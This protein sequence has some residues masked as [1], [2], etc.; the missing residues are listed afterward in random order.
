MEGGNFGSVLNRIAEAG[1]RGQKVRPGDYFDQDGF[2][3]CGT[4]GERRQT[5]VNFPN[6]GQDGAP[7]EI[8]T[9]V[10]ISCRC[11][12]E[13]EEAE[14]KEA[15]ASKDMQRISYLRKASL[16]DELFSKATFDSY[17]KNK[18]NELNLKLCL[19][20]T[21]AFD[22][23]M[24]KNQGLL[25]WGGVGTGKSYSAACIANALLNRKIP[26]VM[27]SFIKLLDIMTG[28]KEENE[29]IINR[30]NVAKL[31]VIDDLGAERGTDTALEKVY[32]IVDS[33]Y[34]RKLPMLLTTNLTIQQMKDE[35]DIR[36]SRIYDRI[37]EVCYPMQ[38]SGKSF[39]K[40]EANRRF[41]EMKRFLEGDL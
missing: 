5:I 15:Q 22:E 4:C 16:M 30:L 40:K 41:E 28:F 33:R 7:A 13:A 25:F 12:R 38:F 36:Y 37:F 31:L 14:K 2:L 11:D 10:P 39:R 20:F 9:K 18:C 32:N 19:R 35:T 3:I 1:F 6:L 24:E 26:V 27:T 21:E 23:M 8:P 17:E 34:R 29:T